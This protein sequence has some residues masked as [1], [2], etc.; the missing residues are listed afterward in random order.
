MLPSALITKP[1]DYE[2][3]K[4]RHAFFIIDD[5]IILIPKGTVDSHFEWLKKQ[6]R[7]DESNYEELFNKI[8]RGFYW[9]PTNSL[10]FYNGVG[11]YFND[12]LEKIAIKFFPKF[13]ELLNL[14]D[15][16]EVFLGPKDNPLDGITYPQKKLI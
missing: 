12:E 14:N 8:A 2:F 15:E 10:Y 11:C 16:T 4:T 3:H 9:P 6:G 13:K 5:E 1:Q 7:V